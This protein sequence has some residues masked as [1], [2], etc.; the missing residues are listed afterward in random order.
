MQKLKEYKD[1]RGLVVILI[2]LR[3]KKIKNIWKWIRI[4]MEKTSRR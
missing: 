4:Y 3:I 1:L 2:N